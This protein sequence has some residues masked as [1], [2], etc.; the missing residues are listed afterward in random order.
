MTK[1]KRYIRYILLAGILLVAG[2]A[3]RE[4]RA[5]IYSIRGNALALLSGTLNV[6][7]DMAVGPK[8]S[9]DLSL[10]VNPIS[11]KKYSSQLYAIQ[12]GARFWR[13][14]P[15]AGWFFG[16]H[17]SAGYYSVGGK[18]FTRKGYLVGPGGSAGYSLLISKRFTIGF[19]AGIGILYMS[20]TKRD[21][22]VPI[23]NDEYIHRINRFVLAPTKL[24][25][26]MV[27]LF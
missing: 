20:E 6:G 13:F 10:Y 26:N 3:A 25:V 21:R 12:P 23:T 1:A 19:E 16:A 4:A 24:G 18:Q 15:N 17:L 14:E 2:G 7:A 22:E 11:G 9:V 27:Y 5:Q 8:T